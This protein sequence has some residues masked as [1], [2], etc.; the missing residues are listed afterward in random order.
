MKILALVSA[1]LVVSAQSQTS[2]TTTP[3]IYE[4]CSVCNP[5][6]VPTNLDADLSRGVS[7]YIP[8]VKTCRDAE[9]L[10]NIGEI[11]PTECVLLRF[12]SP[13]PCGCTDASL[14]PPTVPTAPIAPP[15]LVPTP[16]PSEVSTS[17]PTTEPPSTTLPTSEPTDDPT[18]SPTT[19]PPTFT[20]TVPPTT[21][22]PTIRDTVLPTSMPT[23]QEVPA[24]PSGDEPPNETDAPTFSA[25]EEP[26]GVITGAPSAAPV[27]VQSPTIS[28]TALPSETVVDTTIE[29]PGGVITVAPSATPVAVQSP[30]ISMTAPPSDTVDTTIPASPTTLTPTESPPSTP[31]PSID[32]VDSE[33][34]PSENAD[35]SGDDSS[36]AEDEDDDGNDEILSL[37]REVFYGI[38]AGGALTILLCLT[39]VCRR[40]CCAAAPVSPSN[41]MTTVVA[42]PSAKE[43]RGNADQPPRR[44]GVPALEKSHSIGRM[45]HQAPIASELAIATARAVG[46]VPVRDGSTASSL[47][48]LRPDMMSRT[49]NAPPGRLGL[50]IDTALEGARVQ[51]VSA[52]SPLFGLI[53]KGD[54]IVAINNV[55]TRAM[56]GA[57]LSSLMLKTSGRTRELVVISEDVVAPENTESTKDVPTSA[58]MPIVHSRR[59]PDITTASEPPPPGRKLIMLCTS[60]VLNRRVKSQQERA[61]TALDA[62]KIPYDTLDG[63]NFPELRDE[64][65][66]VS[67]LERGVYPQFFWVDLETGKPTFWGDFE[68]FSL[69]NDN[70][71]LVEEFGG[72]ASKATVM[73]PRE[74]HL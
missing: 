28:M 57:A 25:T 52:K 26:G 23:T 14:V 4:P 41:N 38:V 32:A 12:Q 2:S 56:A 5:G 68:V 10:G 27:G 22:M 8:G 20:P 6:L 50:T 54:V 67:P 7:T 44:D 70:G 63:V 17:S 11:P 42:P 40:A 19:A 72:G 45:R 1:L 58:T 3:G 53:F 21:L 66:A 69:A 64:L 34:E 48:S 24:P 31:T 49:V 73:S 15:S 74:Y 43:E 36:D 9:H 33:L 47:S 39:L 46:G 61:K 59:A 35:D 62:H 65:W 16:A 60:I 51:A 37:R 30:T 13:H 18:T 55:D 29:E 71:R